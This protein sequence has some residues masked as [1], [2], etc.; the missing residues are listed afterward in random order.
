MAKILCVISI[1]LVA[2]CGVL[3]A[4]E[5]VKSSVA[6]EWLKTGKFHCDEYATHKRR[7]ENYAFYFSANAARIVSLCSKRDG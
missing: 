4:D 3:Q 2:F 5:E 7:T 6:P 1:L